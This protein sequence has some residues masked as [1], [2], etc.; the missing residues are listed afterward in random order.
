MPWPS[1][2]HVEIPQPMADRMAKMASVTPIALRKNR[3]A[4]QSSSPRRRPQ[5]TTADRWPRAQATPET[6]NRRTSRRR[7][8]TQAR[9][10]SSSGDRPK[11]ALG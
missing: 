7:A 1:A 8:A 9:A 11:A 2:I 5:Q 4:A 3:G 10:G 6:E